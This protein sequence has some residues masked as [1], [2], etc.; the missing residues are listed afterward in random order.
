[1]YRW[2]NPSVQ[3]AA[4]RAFAACTVSHEKKSALDGVSKEEEHTFDSTY[5]PPTWSPQGDPKKGEADSHPTVTEYDLPSA[6]RIE[7]ALPSAE[8]ATKLADSWET[9]KPSVDD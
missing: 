7:K 6:A 4:G 1:M 9:Q 3:K 5:K 8:E 2:I